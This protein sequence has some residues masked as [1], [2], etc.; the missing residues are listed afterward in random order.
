MEDRTNELLTK[1]SDIIEHPKVW[2]EENEMI[3]ESPSAQARRILQVLKDA[4]M[5]KDPSSQG[6]KTP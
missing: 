3:R 5:L 2:W 6:I 1:I 4:G